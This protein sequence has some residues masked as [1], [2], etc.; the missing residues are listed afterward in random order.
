MDKQ[1][2]SMGNSMDSGSKAS[3][4]PKQE[5]HVVE[6]TS[7]DTF[8]DEAYGQGE[9]EFYEGALKNTEGIYEN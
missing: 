8:E 9:T 6:Y 4:V 2:H 1:D 3:A 5:A 7:N